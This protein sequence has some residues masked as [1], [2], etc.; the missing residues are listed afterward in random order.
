LFSGDSVACALRN[1]VVDEKLNPSTK[2]SL[3]QLGENFSA[4]QDYR[5]TT[6]NCVN[7]TLHLN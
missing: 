3:W 1:F 2:A 4:V 7:Y 6:V 5:E